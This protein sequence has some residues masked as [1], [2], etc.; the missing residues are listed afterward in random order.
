FLEFNQRI[1]EE[2]TDPAVPLLERLKF[3]SIV[4]SNLDEFFMVRVAG[5]K[6]QLKS[7]VM[8]AGPDGMVPSEQLAAIGVR[9][10]AQVAAQERALLSE[11]LPSPR[12]QGIHIL[13][14]AELS[15]QQLEGLRGYFRRQLFPIL[16]PLAI[17]PGHPVPFIKNRT[18]NLAIHLL[19]ELGEPDA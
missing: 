11:I 8:D 6:Q 19:P 15:P 13:K 5:L 9:A 3:I 16:T 7:G 14:V 10:S 12:A 17:D 1:V 4:T 2:A 18:L